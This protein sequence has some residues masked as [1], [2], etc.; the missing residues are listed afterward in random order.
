PEDPQHPGYPQSLLEK[1]GRGQRPFECRPDVVTLGLD[2]VERFGEAVA[3]VDRLTLLGEVETPPQVGRA[4][5][6]L[7]IGLRQLLQCERPQRLEQAVSGSIVVVE[8]ERDHRLAHETADRVEQ[9]VD[10]GATAGTY[11]FS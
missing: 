5:G 11:C 6:L 10:G 1:P 8:V 2:R 4:D 7:F 3:G 9:Y